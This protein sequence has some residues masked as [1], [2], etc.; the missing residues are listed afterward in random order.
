MRFHRNILAIPYPKFP[1]KPLFSAY[2][3]RKSSCRVLERHFRIHENLTKR[4]KKI[5]NAKM[6]RILHSIP[7]QF[8]KYSHTAEFRMK[9]KICSNTPHQAE[10]QCGVPCWYGVLERFSTSG[11]R[12]S[13]W[14]GKFLPIV[15]IKRNFNAE[16]RV[17]TEFAFIWNVR[18]LFE[19]K[20]QI[21]SKYGMRNSTLWRFP[22]D[23]L[24]FCQSPSSKE[25]FFGP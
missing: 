13:A 7:Q 10:F 21:T 23:F 1:Q 4:F 15:C 18:K 25:E 16:F 9:W 6:R 22:Q 19:I 17:D 14:S 2:F 11:L 8:R 24:V 5:K 20:F 3:V 12:N